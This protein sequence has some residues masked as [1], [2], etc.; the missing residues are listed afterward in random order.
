MIR[1]RDY[2]GGP[3]LNS[4]TETPT[5]VAT[6][7]SGIITDWYLSGSYHITANTS[8]YRFDQTT[9][10]I[11][12][13][14]NGLNDGAYMTY[15]VTP[16]DIATTSTLY[17]TSY[18]TP[19]YYS[20]VDPTSLTFVGSN[21]GGIGSIWPSDR[22]VVPSGWTI[23][24]PYG[25]PKIWFFTN[26]STR[27]T[28]SSGS[29]YANYQDS[30]A[31]DC[32]CL[33]FTY[34][35]SATPLISILATNPNDPVLTVTSQHSGS[36]PEDIQLTLD[37]TGGVVRYED[38]VLSLESPVKAVVNLGSDT[39][40]Y[41][42]DIILNNRNN[43]GATSYLMANGRNHYEY[44]GDLSHN[45]YGNWWYYYYVTAKNSS[46]V[47]S[48]KSQTAG[49]LTGCG[50]PIYFRASGDNKRVYLTWTAIAGAS[51]YNIYWSNSPSS[52][53]PS[54]LITIASGTQT[55]FTHTGL[56]NGQPYYYTI[57]SINAADGVITRYGTASDLPISM[58][59]PDTHNPGAPINFGAFGTSDT[60]GTSYGRTFYLTWDHLP[61]A[62]SFTV[63]AT[64]FPFPVI[65]A[66]PISGFS[67]LMANITA[68]PAFPSATVYIYP[69]TKVLIAPT[70]HV[71]NDGSDVPSFYF[72]YDGYG[73]PP[74]I[75]YTSLN[76]GVIQ[77]AVLAANWATPISVVRNE[78]IVAWCVFPGVLGNSY[79]ANLS[80]SKIITFK[81]VTPTIST[82]AT[83]LG[84]NNDT[85]V[86]FGQ[87]DS[88][89]TGAVT[90]YYTTDG[91]TPTT[92]SPSTPVNTNVTITA[93]AYLV[94][95]VLKYMAHR[96]NSTDSDVVSTTLSW[97]CSTPTLTSGKSTDTLNSGSDIITLGILTTAN[98][99]VIRY[100]TDGSTP[101]AASALYNTS[102]T[103]STNTTI[104][105]I[106]ISLGFT[107]SD[108]LTLGPYTFNCGGVGI[109]YTAAPKYYNQIP[110]TLTCPLTPLATIYWFIYDGT[111]L[112]S[113]GTTAHNG[114]VYFEGNLT[115]KAYA[116]LAGY[117]NGPTSQVTFTTFNV[118]DI[119]FK[120]TTD[121]S[122]ALTTIQGRTFTIDST[123]TGSVTYFYTVDGSVPSQTN[124]T[125]IIGKT[126]T[127]W[128]S[129]NLKIVAIKLYYI[130]Y[131]SDTLQ[132][133]TAA[134]PTIN[135]S[136]Y[137][138]VAGTTVPIILACATGIPIYYTTDG[139]TPTTA[140]AKFSGSIP[141]STNCT[142]KALAI[143][144][145]G[146]Y[147]TSNLF[148]STAFVFTVGLVSIG[149]P[150]AIQY[151]SYSGITMTDINTPGASIYYTTDGSTPTIGS[152]LYSGP[153]SLNFSCVIQA[154][155]VLAGCTSSG[156]TSTATI[157]FMCADPTAL[158]TGNTTASPTITFADTTVGA[159]IYYTIDGSTPSASSSK[160]TVA[161][162]PLSNTTYKFIAILAGYSNSNVMSQTVTVMV[163]QPTYNQIPGSRALQLSDWTL[164][165]VTGIGLYY[166]TDGSTPN[167][168]TLG[169]AGNTT[170]KMTNS[171]YWY[172][173]TTAYLPSIDFSTGTPDNTLV[174]IPSLGSG[175]SAAFVTALNAYFNQDAIGSLST[176][177]FVG[178]KF[179]SWAVGTNASAVVDWTQMTRSSYGV[180]GTPSPNNAV[181]FKAPSF[182]ITNDGNIGGTCTITTSPLLSVLTP[183]LSVCNGVA[184]TI[185]P[186]GIRAYISSGTNNY[187]LAKIQVDERVVWLSPVSTN[188]ST[189]LT[190]YS[191]TFQ[192]LL[193]TVYRVTLDI[194]F[195]LNNAYVAINLPTTMNLDTRQFNVGAPIINALANNP[196]VSWNGNV[197]IGKPTNLIGNPYAHIAYFIYDASITNP[198]IPTDGYYT[199][200][201]GVPTDVGSNTTNGNAYLDGTKLRLRNTGLTGVLQTFDVEATAMNNH[202]NVVVDGSSPVHL[203]V[204]NLAQWNVWT[205]RW[206]AAG[207]KNIGADSA[208][209]Y[210][211][212][213]MNIYAYIYFDSYYSFSSG[214]N[215][216]LTYTNGFDYY[217]PQNSLTVGILYYKLFA[218]S[219]I[220]NLLQQMQCPAP[221]TSLT[222]V[223]EAV[224]QTLPVFGNIISIKQLT[225]S[226]IGMAQSVLTASPD[227]VFYLNIQGVD[228]VF[229]ASGVVE[230]SSNPTGVVNAI[231]LL[232]YTGS[233]LTVSA[234]I[235]LIENMSVGIFTQS[236]G[237]INS[238]I[239][240]FNLSS[241]FTLP[242]VVVMDA[243]DLAAATYLNH[244]FSASTNIVFVSAFN[245]TN[246][247][248]S[249]NQVETIHFTTDGTDPTT[250]SSVQTIVF[251]VV[252]KVVTAT[253][254]G[255]S[256][257]TSVTANGQVLVDAEITRTSSTT[258]MAYR[259]SPG[260]LSSAVS[261]NKFYVLNAP[262]AN[263]STSGLIVN[264][265]TYNIDFNVNLV[266]SES[267]GIVIY[268]TDGVN[269]SVSID[270]VNTSASLIAAFSSNPAATFS[271][272]GSY[273]E[274]GRTVYYMQNK[275]SGNKNIVADGYAYL[276][277]GN[278]SFYD[279]SMSVPISQ[280]T[281][282]KVVCFHSYASNS[283]STIVVSPVNT[284]IY[285]MKLPQP[286]VTLTGSSIPV[287]TYQSVTSGTQFDHCTV[288]VENSGI[289]NDYYVYYNSPT[290]APPASNLSL[291]AY[292]PLLSNITQI[293]LTRSGWTPSDPL[294]VTGYTLTAITASWFTCNYTNG[295]IL[296]NN[297][298]PIF[299]S[300]VSTLPP[301]RSMAAGTYWTAWNARSTILT[302]YA[303]GSVLR[304]NNLGLGQMYIT[305]D[306]S[307]P[308]PPV[309]MTGLVRANFNL[310][311]SSPDVV[312]LTQ[313]TNI[314]Y[315]L[316]WALYATTAATQDASLPTPAQ[317]PLYLSKFSSAVVT[318]T[319]NVRCGA[320]VVTGY[321][322]V[323]QAALSSGNLFVVLQSG[324]TGV[325]VTVNSG[326]V[327]DGIRLQ[328]LNVTDYNSA[329]IAC[330]PASLITGG[331]ITS[332]SDIQTNVV[333]NIAVA[334]LPTT[335]Q[336]QNITRHMVLFVRTE[337]VNCYPSAVVEMI[338]VSQLP[339][340]VFNI[341]SGY[342]QAKSTP[343]TIS[344]PANFAI[345]ETVTMYYTKTAA[346]DANLANISN[347]TTGSLSLVSGGSV[348][349]T[350]PSS[351]AIKAMAT[352]PNNMNSSVSS[353]SVAIVA[354]TPAVL[355]LRNQDGTLNTT[356]IIDTD[357][358]TLRVYVN[359]SSEYTTWSAT[360]GPGSKADT[361]F[362]GV[363]T[364]TPLKTAIDSTG[365][366]SGVT[367][368]PTA[369]TTP[370]TNDVTGVS[371]NGQVY[372]WY[373]DI[374][375]VNNLY[376]LWS[377]INA[378]FY[379][380]VVAVNTTT[381][382]IDTS[383]VPIPT[384][385]ITFVN[386]AITC[387][388]PT[389]TYTADGKTVT[390]TA[391]YPPLVGVPSDT[392]HPY[393][394]NYLIWWTTDGSDP[395]TNPNGTAQSYNATIASPTT[396]A[397]NVPL[398]LTLNVAVT[399]PLRQTVTSSFVFTMRVQT[400]YF[401]IADDT[402]LDNFEDSAIITTL[403][404]TIGSTLWY[405]TDGTSPD[406][407]NQWR[408]KFT[409]PIILN[410]VGVITIKV[411]G[412]KPG[413]A[414]SEIGDLTVNVFDSSDVSEDLRLPGSMSYRTLTNA[415]TYK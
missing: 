206:T 329:A 145:T 16:D 75:Y 39:D 239:T 248:D 392:N 379:Q 233:N 127:I 227:S 140:S 154:F 93:Q 169:Q 337:A 306:G 382:G 366:G 164:P 201:A 363:N 42:Y 333:N 319:V 388:S 13:E 158:V 191:G 128:G 32:I 400:P 92:S 249:Y 62:T 94:G 252:N 326:R 257:N 267:T 172:A 251:T 198:V 347:P 398:S 371:A 203:S 283:I 33:S 12:K 66:S 190:T 383:S 185:M 196:M 137:A 213:G 236:P 292:V 108:V 49:I 99:T 135:V 241:S 299:T 364:N 78:S 10:N 353:L 176:P 215:E 22:T 165:N 129:C 45:A 83:L 386:K 394:Q 403:C 37:S 406:I 24:I 350:I 345:A 310:S 6:T 85:V 194:P 237:F 15:Y 381:Q 171:F 174:N 53:V 61:A 320:P 34:T 302:G 344:S 255:V 258:I 195:L 147:L 5:K 288:A 221:S 295:Q 214:Y 313:T 58:A 354:V 286:T 25:T 46:S 89:V 281:T 307:T 44:V 149:Y 91:S 318:W 402:T 362:G 415:Q 72:S 287:G 285:T 180:Y 17:N 372:N 19:I 338:F 121:T 369:W 305:N 328:Y 162:A 274:G 200:A 356:G 300:S 134:F 247:I 90:I 223:A 184:K 291:N 391:P 186:S 374:P 263:S 209:V 235:S 261:T 301:S 254:N 358:C 87:I 224:G 325:S 334:S 270:S 120:T 60:A 29:T 397:I 43:I 76:T 88:A 367:F 410:Q 341:A 412:T 97:K 271:N 234:T 23:N 64:P 246:F 314:T 390:L 370:L 181:A 316:V 116:A 105:A 331:Q 240:A 250:S 293:I 245:M 282:L 159:S 360:A 231:H 324:G 55:Y 361:L 322:S 266:E 268:T 296:I 117:N 50:T 212:K 275:T 152:T 119:L 256:V 311:I 222:T 349:A 238:V 232:T 368:T 7:P 21:S 387:S 63:Y 143:D 1:I 20:L 109:G 161:L 413:W 170:V 408:W 124:G 380:W 8:G 272:Y 220:A 26:N 73:S 378:T 204:T 178:F 273:T 113:S 208:T 125:M 384:Q 276:I 173:N 265:G 226:F 132:H 210:I 199:F 177:V 126:F 304:M 219:P 332:S 36:M 122:A 54:N 399:Y 343:L 405:T 189:G 260:W 385:T 211:N 359:T 279:P 2:N 38:L 290:L 373:F 317:S 133:L 110:I 150:T 114:V 68:V 28:T 9:L 100:T 35:Y 409:K 107:N 59:I 57:Q 96:A 81:L 264:S 278:G 104:K 141:I 404:D 339:A 123:T 168:A 205:D 82:A 395:I 47:E 393:A 98:G 414:D 389:G 102:I 207:V 144:T 336:V 303:A 130:S 346:G 259:S 103:I 340:P 69:V 31:F 330:N 175:Q 146:A 136:Q 309:S 216:N 193:P 244:Y 243:A 289:Y 115:I 112:I 365:N 86:Q 79:T 111:T 18:N 308:N 148:T 242:N 376:S 11:T 138:Y 327:G 277:G 217:I 253:L 348:E 269:P 229:N 407:T 163:S 315:K 377:E 284:Y 321:Q 375:I 187:D 70:I 357:H 352:A 262:S 4:L 14:M 118:Q 30:V 335:G 56:T 74:A 3:N 202:N 80:P 401:P 48:A 396:P 297:A 183:I 218:R 101:T 153:I 71:I 131:I 27:N 151:N 51:G 67:T 355:V 160:Y 84:N 106:A 65:L 225:A 52:I 323:L 351:I 167:P 312:N 41:L 188:P 230:I 77:N 95:G 157:T 142:I 280:T 155:A 298:A 156:V 411:I 342:Y 139:S 179:V 197:S 294:T 40:K 182:T 166:T 192:V 228:I